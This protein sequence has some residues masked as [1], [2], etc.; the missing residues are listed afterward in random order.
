MQLVRSADEVLTVSGCT[1]VCQVMHV[2][3]LSI[4]IAILLLILM[5]CYDLLVFL[6]LFGNLDVEKRHIC[7]SLFSYDLLT[8]NHSSCVYMEV[9]HNNRLIC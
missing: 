2:K 3:S 8:T 1:L 9:G 5:K 6:A 4:F 7:R